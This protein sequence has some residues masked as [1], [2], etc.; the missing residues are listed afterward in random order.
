MKTVF[1]DVFWIAVTAIIV[2]LPKALL[3]ANA[4]MQTVSIKMVL[5]TQGKG[6]CPDV[7]YAGPFVTMKTR[8]RLDCARMCASREGCLHHAF[9]RNNA[10]CYHYY[11]SPA[12][13]TTADDCNFM[14]ASRF[15]RNRV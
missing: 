5:S 6:R 7:A 8:S 15:T 3:P 12:T 11:S 1:Q 14:V 2:F 13:L 4:Q 9:Y 10:S